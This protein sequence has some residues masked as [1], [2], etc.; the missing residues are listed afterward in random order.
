MFKNQVSGSLSELFASEVHTELALSLLQKIPFVFYFIYE[1]TEQSSVKAS[2][3]LYG[4][5]S[6]SG[7][8]KITWSNVVVDL[9][10]VGLADIDVFF[11]LCMRAPAADRALMTT[12]M[13]TRRHQPEDS[14]QRKS[15]RLHDPHRRRRRKPTGRTLVAATRSP[16]RRRRQRST[17][18]DYQGQDSCDDD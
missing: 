6:E 5:W 7:Q 8:M 15:L 12:S 11:R 16:S 1:Q 17:C 13:E 10:P 18:R 2:N 3:C 4:K 14:S 9:Q